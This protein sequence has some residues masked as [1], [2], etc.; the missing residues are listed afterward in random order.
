MECKVFMVRDK[1]KGAHVQKND[2]W[3][4][5]QTKMK[6][7]LFQEHTSIFEVDRG[8]STEKIIMLGGSA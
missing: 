3:L 6:S 4:L 7:D 8:E 5:S 2:G 1:R